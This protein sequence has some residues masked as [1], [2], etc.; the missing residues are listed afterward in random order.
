MA[1]T[2]KTNSHSKNFEKVKSYYDKGLWKE[3]RVREAVVR[4]WIT[5]EE[6]DEILTPI[7]ESEDEEVDA[8]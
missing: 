6:C 2:K 5:Q 3:S 1:K 7:N 8:I 4:N